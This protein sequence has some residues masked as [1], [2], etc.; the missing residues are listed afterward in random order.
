[1]K[2]LIKKIDYYQVVRIYL[3]VITTA[4]LFISVIALDRAV[5]ADQFTSNLR[6]ANIEG[7]VRANEGRVVLRRDLRDDIKGI[8]QEIKETRTIPHSLFPEA[9]PKQFQRVL[10]DSIKRDQKTVGRKLRR[11]DQIP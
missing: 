9:S 7:C 10:K 4:T 5:E 6:T 2:N 3:L 1:M 8:K 11:I